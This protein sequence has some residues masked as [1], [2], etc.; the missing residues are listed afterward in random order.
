[1]FILYG[2]NLQVTIVCRKKAKNNSL[3]NKSSNK[4]RKPIFKNKMNVSL[5]TL[6]ND[7]QKP[8]YALHTYSEISGVD[9]IYA[10]LKFFQNSVNDIN[11]MI[12]LQGVKLL[13][14]PQPL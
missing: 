2:I 10:K 6:K 7:A 14:L 4:C 9:I 3:P 13:K 1:M 11:D 8:T 5:S 12:D